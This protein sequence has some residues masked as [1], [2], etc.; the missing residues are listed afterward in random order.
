MGVRH[1]S[2]AL[3]IAL[4]KYEDDLHDVDQLLKET[5]HQEGNFA[6]VVH[7]VV[8]QQ[9]APVSQRAAQSQ[10]ARRLTQNNQ[11]SRAPHPIQTEPQEQPTSEQSTKKKKNKFVDF[12]SN[13]F[14]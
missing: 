14:D 7:Q 2:F 3:S 12:F 10:P 1:P 13:F 9:Q 6:S 11:P 5:V 4:C 8:Q